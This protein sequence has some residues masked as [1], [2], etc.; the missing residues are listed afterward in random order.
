MR[1][2]V[3]YIFLLAYLPLGIQAQE[4]LAPLDH[5]PL[6]KVREHTRSFAK[7]TALSLPLFEDFTGY[8]PYPDSMVWVDYEV[9]VNNTMCV[10]PVSRGCATF[11]GLNQYGYPYD[12]L[13]KFALVRA[14]SLTLNPMDLSANQP[15]DSI[16]LSFFYQPQGRGFEPETTDS[17]M[18]FFRK[19]NGTWVKVWSKEGTLLLP[20]RQAMVPLTDT[21][22]FYSGFQFRFVNKVSVNTTDDVWNL[23]YIRMGA[24]R[25]ILDTAVGDAAFTAD[26]S[27]M[28][29]DYTYM[30]YRHFLANANGERSTQLTDSIRNNYNGGQNLNWFFAAREKVSNTPLANG[31]GAVNLNAYQTQAI[32]LNTYT[33]TVPL[34]G[35]Y[36]RVVFENKFYIESVSSSDNK[37][38][39]T[40]IKEQVFDN[41]LAYDDGTAEMAYYLNLSPNLPGKIAIEHHLNEPD[42]LQGVSIYFGRQVP[43]GTNKTFSVAVYKQLQ[44]VNGAT[45]DQ[46][47]LQQDFMLPYYLPVNNFYNYKLD[48]P[49]SL[50]AG[51]FYIATIQ[52]AF[53]GSDSLYFGLDRNREQGN[54]AYY[55]VEN[56]WIESTISG[57]IMIRPL[58]GQT[59]FNT[60][61]TEPGSGFAGEKTNFSIFPNPASDYVICDYKGQNAT[62]HITDIQ[63]RVLRQGQLPAD[64]RIDVSGL[65][66][67][68]YLLRVDTNAGHSSPQKFL[69]Q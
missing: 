8:S 40:V 62:Y 68:M 38:N 46:L 24:G 21:S 17:L 65:V 16:Y 9:Y 11:D 39:D 50:P 12:T 56:L 22:Y 55:N 31:S 23:D 18:L 28:L 53:G 29:N 2:R 27:F 34:G 4:M 49:L 67:G 3:L 36:D 1:V 6:L 19:S 25:T 60:G 63:G 13:N 37:N 52:P 32:A 5:N 57:A 10:R 20:F 35:T 33:N 30:P 41:Y 51:A 59:V 7:S 69:K 54:H 14:D 43:L 48:N 47:L 64:R 44:G 15:G 61:I 42:V 45:Q 26:P 66:P 58:V